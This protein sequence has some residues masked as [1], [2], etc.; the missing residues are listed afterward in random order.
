MKTVR[1]YGADWC[2]MTNRTLEHL[3]EL[4]VPYDYID[5]DKN[6]QAAAWVKQQN[7]GKEKKPTLDINGTILVEPTDEDLDEVLR[8][9]QILPA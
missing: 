6:K 1:V 8:D 3:D 4:G 9:Q 5:I 2:A 7:N